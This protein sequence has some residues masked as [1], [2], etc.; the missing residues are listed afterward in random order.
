MH[1]AVTAEFHNIGIMAACYYCGAP[2]TTIDHVPPKTARDR[3]IALG[4]HFTPVELPACSECNSAIGARALWTASERKAFVK[5]W[6]RQR[7]AKYLRI[8]P[9]TE[10]ELAPLGDQLRGYILASIERQRQIRARISW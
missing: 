6:L 10:S 7:Y 3:L 8:P 2:G 9:W 1:K 5:R 4:R